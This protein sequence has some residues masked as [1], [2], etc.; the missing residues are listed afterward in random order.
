MPAITRFAIDYLAV[1]SI[2]ESEGALKRLFTCKEW[3]N[4][5]LSKSCTG[6]KV[7]DIVSNRRFWSR[8]SSVV[9]VTASLVTVLR[10]ADADKKATMGILYEGIERAKSAIGEKCSF[11][12]K[13]IEIIERMWNTKIRRPIHYAGK[14]IFISL[15]CFIVNYFFMKF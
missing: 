11:V 15:E 12:S 13:V 3:L 8:C 7:D 4:G 2:R 1:D 14:Y 10:M 5:R 6:I 9:E